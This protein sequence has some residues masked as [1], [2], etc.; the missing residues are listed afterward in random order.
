MAAREALIEP[1]EGDPERPATP[2]ALIKA[3][4]A[5]GGRA[6]AVAGE[7]QAAESMAE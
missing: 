2:S 3:V 6:A 7:E 1:R 5:A 4:E